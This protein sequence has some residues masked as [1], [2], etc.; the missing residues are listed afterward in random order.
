MHSHVKQN[1]FNLCK[2]LQIKIL[3]K[4]QR[5][6]AMLQG[7]SFSLLCFL[8][9]YHLKQRRK[10]LIIRHLSSKHLLV[11][12]NNR[13]NSVRR[14]ETSSE[15]TIKTPERHYQRRCAVFIVNFVD[16]SNLFLVFLLLT[17]SR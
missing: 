4:Q 2:D 10:I 12:V 8:K 1:Q 16:I 6:V 17:L 15:V 9:T 11:E 3:V 5:N 13:S 14:C 7:K